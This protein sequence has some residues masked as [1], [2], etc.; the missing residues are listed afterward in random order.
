MSAPKLIPHIS[1][2]LRVTTKLIQALNLLRLTT[3]ALKE[4]LNKSISENPL[5]QPT[6]LENLY[7]NIKSLISSSH[8][9]FDKT[10]LTAFDEISDYAQNLQ[11]DKASLHDHLLHQLKTS[12]LN[13]NELTI[14]ENI[15]ECL[16]SNGYMTSSLAELSQKYNMP[17]QMVE[18][19]L[20]AI[21]TFDPPGVGARSLQ[22]CLLIQLKIKDMVHSLAYTIVKSSFKYLSRKNFSVIAKK[23]GA[24]IDK[25]KEAVKIITS[26]NP[27]PGAV[28]S[29]DKNVMV[30]PD[31][32][33]TRHKNR[34]KIELDEK[35]LPSLNINSNYLKLLQDQNAS[36]EVKQFI[37][38]RLKNA[39]WLTKAMEERRNNILKVMN[40]IVKI[41]KQAILR[42]FSYIKP[43]TLTEIAKISGLHHS[44]V[45]RI[46]ANKHASTPQGTIKIKDL[47]SGKY[48]LSDG[49]AISSKNI[50][51]KIERIIIKGNQ[52]IPLT[53]KAIA[54]I[55]RKDGIQIS[56]RA[57]AKYRKK[58]NIPSSFFRASD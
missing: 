58:L 55:L 48:K 17:V 47:F 12:F 52:K 7:S 11:S 16:D 56:R 39:L 5:L 46:V 8:D 3:P 4:Y 41:Q 22:E 21:Q 57:V 1:P 19:V 36:Q 2:K 31:V 54:D 15:I 49:S 43:L 33:I 25:V 50:L 13:D 37:T 6:D 34:L 27:K 24:S 9:S 38:E 28:F 35:E 29:R 32:I 10:R 23:T 42:G 20:D 53:D 40:A 51:S 14:G 26:L 18:K 45:S 44:T 30:I